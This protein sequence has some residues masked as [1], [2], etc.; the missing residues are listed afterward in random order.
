MAALPAHRPADPVAGDAT[1]RVLVVDDERALRE[2][3]RRLISGSIALTP[4]VRIAATPAEAMREAAL[5]KPH[6][7]VLDLDLAGEDGLALLPHFVPS[8]QVLVLTSHGDPAVRARAFA[9]GASAFV[10]KHEPASTLL[11]QLNALAARH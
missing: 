7:V 3:L 11:A 6:V 1:L 2:G 10:E 8:A 9:L 4:E 5:L